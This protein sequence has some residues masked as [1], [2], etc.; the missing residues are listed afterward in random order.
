M[1]ATA[2]SGVSEWRRHWALPIAAG[3]GYSL[4]VIH[5]YSLGAFFEPLQQEFGWSRAQTSAGLTMTGFVS[6]LAAF[7]IGLLVDRLGPRRVGIVGALLMGVT[8]ALLSTATGDFNNWLLLWGVLAIA[9]FWVQTTVWTSAIASRFTQSRGLAFAVTLSGASL[10]AF[11]FPSMA[12]DFITAHGW[13]NAFIYM[14]ALWGA[15]VL[16]VLVIFFRGAQDQRRESQAAAPAVDLP[17][18]TL[19]QGLRSPTF[20]KLL[21]AAL[22]FAFTALGLVVHF[23]SILTDSGVDRAAAASIAGLVGIFSIVGRLGMGLL[24]DRFPAHMVGALAYLIPIPACLLLLFDSANP[25]SQ[26]AAAALVGLTVG[27]EVDV[28]AY[29]ASRHF[30]LKNFGGLFGCMVAALSMGTAFGPLAAG[31]VFDQYGSYTPFLIVTIVLM[32][33]SSL[34]LAS[35]KPPAFSETPA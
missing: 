31:H 19:A 12:V 30:G 10:A 6:A 25:T 26:L 13:R 1:N 27:A 29:L 5:I 23:V 28:I 14:G 32:S 22:L 7:P 33:V 11:I 20:Y 3:L 8:F 18:L 4:G 21:M 24:L 15:L 17:G 16:V 2:T 34:A 35:L 9:T